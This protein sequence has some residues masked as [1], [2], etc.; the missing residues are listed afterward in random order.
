LPVKAPEDDDIPFALGLM[1]AWSGWWTTALR[2]R[3]L[4]AERDIAGCFVATNSFQ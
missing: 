3:R 4:R 1:S 2:Y